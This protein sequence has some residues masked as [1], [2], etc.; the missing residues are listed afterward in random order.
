VKERT[1]VAERHNNREL[2]RALASG[3]FWLGDCLAVPHDGEL[4]HNYTSVFLVQGDKKSLIV[5]TG[6]QKDWAA[7]QKQVDG[8]MAQGVPAI[9]YVF[10]THTEMPHA[11]NLG[12]WLSKFPNAVAVGDVRDY[13]LVFPDFA[14]RFVP[15][16]VGD[17]IDLGGTEF[18]FLEAVIRDLVTSL[19][20]YDTRRRALFPGDGFA[21]MHHHLAH[22][23]GYTAEEL[24]D[25][26]IP[27]FTA[28]FAEYALYWTRFTDMEPKIQQL[29]E[30]LAGE[31]PVD[32]ILPAHG[33]PILD[34]SLTVAK[35][36]EGLRLGGS[37]ASADA[38]WRRT[39]G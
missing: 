4:V 12:R 17:R 7:L 35:V 8:L 10:A 16:G 18:V 33:C 21:Y 36:K 34:P 1:G 23:C 28:I 38:A 24:P 31:D 30:L 13:H 14:D 3:L 26:P 19:W 22:E 6:H 20:G 15:L 9:D 2:P 27:E 25:L 5:D 11:A 37:V 29:E 32:I 39:G